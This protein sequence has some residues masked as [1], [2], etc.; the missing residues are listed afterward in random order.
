MCCLAVP[1]A[2]GP[3]TFL[4][5]GSWQVPGP[6]VLSAIEAAVQAEQSCSSPTQDSLGT[7]VL[8]TVLADATAARVPALKAAI[9]HSQGP[10]PGLSAG[11]SSQEA[12]PQQH[13]S[14]SGVGSSSSGGTAGRGADSC[15]LPQPHAGSAAA[16]ASYPDN[17]GVAAAWVGL[18]ASCLKATAA[19]C[20]SS[21]DSAAGCMTQPSS[22][23]TTAVKPA[24]GGSSPGAGQAGANAAAESSLN[25]V[26]AA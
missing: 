7:K 6:A 21:S 16:L 3:G 1:A 17:P 24:V 14:S 9:S 15:P 8:L 11:G 12:L 26:C 4:S 13:S 10:A 20:C 23:S 18:L 2:A 5:Q 19:S 22:S 25:A